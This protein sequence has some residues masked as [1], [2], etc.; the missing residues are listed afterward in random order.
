[1]TAPE[2]AGPVKNGG[3]T[4]ATREKERWATARVKCMA[5]GYRWQAVFPVVPLDDVELE[6]PSCSS[7]RGIVQIAL[8]RVPSQDGRDP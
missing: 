7:M 4:G 6:C 2:R 8:P 1:M 5:C 3:A